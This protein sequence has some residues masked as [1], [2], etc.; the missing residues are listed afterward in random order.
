MDR[1]KFVTAAGMA[2]TAGLLA[3][4]SKQPAA[5]CAQSDDQ[6]A[7]SAQEQIEWKMVTTWP[8]DFPG[9][10][11]GANTLARLVGEM[12]GGR[13]GYLHLPNMMQPGLI[14]FARGFYHQ[15]Y[16]TAF[17]IDDR[18]NAGGFVGDQIIDRLERKHR[19]DLAELVELLPERMKLWCFL[20]FL[21]AFAF[22]DE[23]AGLLDFGFLLG[24][25]GVEISHSYELVEFGAQSA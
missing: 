2:G 14:E 4:C 19:C 5:D 20:V 1:R 7:S 11:T 16:K 3:A 9:L 17:I 24:A 8:R 15:Y 12:S 18:Y 22:R 21:L 23:N 10:G 6:Q 13:I 25:A